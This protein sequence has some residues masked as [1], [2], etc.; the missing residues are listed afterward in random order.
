METSQPLR[1]NSP[2]SLSI[3]WASAFLLFTLIAVTGLVLGGARPWILLPVYG[4]VALLIL[5]QA[6]TIAVAPLARRPRFDAVNSFAAAFLVYGTI[7]Y[8]TAP[9]EYL[10]RIDLLS[11]VSAAAVFWTAR[12][13]LARASHGLFVLGGLAAVA[14]IAVV[15]AFWLRLHP[16]FDPYGDKIHVGYFPRLTGTFCSPNHF[17]AFLNLALAAVL[18]PVLFLRRNWVIR[19]VLVYIAIALV[20]GIGFS[21][22]RGAWIGLV[23]VLI[24]LTVFCMRHAALKWY[25][26][27]GGLALLLAGSFLVM[28]LA[29]GVQDRLA[30]VTKQLGNNYG[31][32]YCRVRLAKTA[33]KIIGDHF[34]FGTG[35]GT[36]VHE[37]PRYQDSTYDTFA[38]YTHDDY[39]NLWCDYGFIG[40]FLGVGF[41]V[42]TAIGL[43]RRIDKSA[44]SGHR[45]LVCAGFAAFAGIAAH[46][47]LDFSLHIPACA[48]TFF[49]LAGLGLRRREPEPDGVGPR[50][51]AWS[52]AGVTIAASL[53]FASVVI[54]TAH[55]Y[56]PYHS[57]EDQIGTLPFAEALPPLKA[58]ATADPQFWPVAGVLGD[59]YRVEADTHPAQRAELGGE[60]VRWY[61]RALDAD[62]LDDSLLIRLG[63]AYDV[64]ERHDEALA[65]TQ[66]A[67]A[68]QPYNGYFRI[69]L[70]RHYWLR[71]Q[72]PEAI[73]AYEQAL[74]CPYGTGEAA[75]SLKTLRA[76]HPIAPLPPPPTPASDTPIPA[77]N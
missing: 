29:P 62:P 28:S 56:Y 17:A 45:V 68:L 9:V 5:L 51:I 32:S 67:V 10:A 3:S 65:R 42:T 73:A 72:F 38:I 23:V 52:L 55:G 49:T 50:W 69:A 54:K 60:S 59:Y 16:E 66:Q 53:T 1:I 24:A 34:W 26:P 7:R 39:L 46:S 64:L 30:E 36:F 25:W 58:A 12:Y 18:A 2:W 37:H 43:G 75:P 20:L 31:Q 63:T 11:I 57:I 14:L 13:G 15:F 4:L 71:G 47:F 77:T 61:L 48:L 40:F 70:G 6:G 21:I 35:P 22:S 76:L 19:I 8:F 41:V 74:Q 33:F 44:P 27:V